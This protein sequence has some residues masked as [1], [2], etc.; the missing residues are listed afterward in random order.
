MLGIGE[1]TLYRKISKFG[2][3]RLTESPAAGAAAQRPEPG[4]RD[5]AR[6]RSAW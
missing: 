3:G 4:P 5:R 6:A 2:L 1:R